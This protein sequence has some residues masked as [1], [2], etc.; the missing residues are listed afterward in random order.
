L[1][2]RY[3]RRL[4]GQKIP[5]S[6]TRSPKDIDSVSSWLRFKQQS[7][8]FENQFRAAIKK[9]VTLRFVIEKPL[10]HHLPKWVKATQ[11][12]HENFKLKTQPA[13]VAAS[14][15]IFDANTAAVAF[16][17][18]ASLSRGPDLWTTNQS[19]TALCQAHFDA[20]WIQTS[21]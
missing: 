21:T 15:S 17:S 20:A 8:R 5:K 6:N 19:L 10:N 18:N 4:Q 14:V 7:F 3:L 16:N 2:W 11:E 12:K 1:F 9:G 13:P